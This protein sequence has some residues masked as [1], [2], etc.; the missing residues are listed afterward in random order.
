MPFAVKTRAAREEEPDPPSSSA[1]A[2]SASPASSTRAT[3]FTLVA[4]EP[5]PSLHRRLH[6]GQ[7]PP[8]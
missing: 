5:F 2:T 4:V 8:R 7:G 6:F 1:P 3:V